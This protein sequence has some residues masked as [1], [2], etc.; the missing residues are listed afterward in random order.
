MD[1]TRVFGTKSLWVI[2]QHLTVQ[3]PRKPALAQQIIPQESMLDMAEVR[4]QERAKCAL[5]ITAAGRHHV[6][7][8]GP[9]GSGK[10]IMVARMASILT[11][12][13]AMEA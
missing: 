11:P 7:F 5:E 1:A 13:N 2:I 6:F 4:G 8:V 3:A 9:P 12:L 10:S